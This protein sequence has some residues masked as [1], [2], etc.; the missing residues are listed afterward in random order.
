MD[1]AKFYFW[2]KPPGLLCS[3]HYQANLVSFSFFNFSFAH[4]KIHAFPHSKI[5]EHFVGRSEHLWLGNIFSTFFPTKYFY[6]PVCILLVAGHW[7]GSHPTS[8]QPFSPNFYYHQQ[9][10]QHFSFLFCAV[11]FCGYRCN[12]NMSNTQPLSPQFLLLATIVATL[13]SVYR[14]NE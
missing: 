2:T 1:F 9:S 5:V 14:C 7:F 8:M 13:F 4:T 10:L 11:L 3:I 12:W 6:I